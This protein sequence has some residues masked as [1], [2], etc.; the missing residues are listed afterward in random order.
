MGGM[1][2]AVRLLLFGAWVLWI[3][4]QPYGYSGSWTIV[5]AFERRPECV[6]ERAK[7]EEKPGQLGVPLRTDRPPQGPR[8]ML[9]L[10]D[11]MRPPE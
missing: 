10:P 1:K 7:L 5:D 4:S 6:S 9:C 11:T 8:P 3:R 2:V